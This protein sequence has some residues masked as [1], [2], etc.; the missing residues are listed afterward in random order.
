MKHGFA[1]GLA[2]GSLLNA[3]PVNAQPSSPPI[4]WDAGI[5]LGAAVYGENRDLWQSAR[6]A[7]GL[8]GEL[9][10]GRTQNR[11]FGFGPVAFAGLTTFGERNAGLGTQLLVPVHEYLPL[12][13]G[14]GLYGVDRDDQKARS[15]G[16]ASVGWGLRSFNY[17][18]SYSMA[19]G[20]LFEA[21]R[22]F[23][24]EPVTTWVGSIQIDTAALVL[25][26]LW[27]INAFRLRRAR[28]PR[29][30]GRYTR[31][32]SDSRDRGDAA[33][34]MAPRRKGES[35]R[36]GFHEPASKA[37]SITSRGRSGRRRAS[38]PSRL[39]REETRQINR[40]VW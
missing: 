22:D 17:H 31:S 11:S 38:L 33:E 39:C 35:S 26:V 40:A 10:L 14:A 5:T 19:G 4:Q 18:S 23:A 3:A 16:F 32:A 27:A 30:A 7:A 29:G 15:G 28:A 9:F 36:R 8:R 6:F 13:I 24:S 12:V 21:R 34:G 37:V 2:A 25:P 1:L 20:L